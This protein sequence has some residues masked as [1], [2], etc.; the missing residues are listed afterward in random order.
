MPNYYVFED[1]KG[2][3]YTLWDYMCKNEYDEP[4][5]S[6]IMKAKHPLKKIGSGY[7]QNLLDLDVLTKEMKKQL[8]R[9]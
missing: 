9:K 2:D 5:P 4:L 7:C 1:Q 6:S 3:V 8:N